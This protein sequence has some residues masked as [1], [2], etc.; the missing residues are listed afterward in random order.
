[1]YRGDF[2]VYFLFV[3]VAVIGYLIGS[4][5]SSIIVGKAYGIDIRSKGSGNAGTT[6]TLRVLGKKAA[7][8]VLVGDFLKGIISFEA[9]YLITGSSH[10]GGMIAGTA[11]ILGHVWPVYFGFKG[12][13]GV[14]TSLAV[15]VMMDWVTALIL[16]AVFAVVV[17]ITRFVSLGSIT[18][19]VML[20]I[21]TILFGRPGTQIVFSL[22]IALLVI[23]MHRGNIKR[24]LEHSESKLGSKKN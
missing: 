13:K 17:A 5:N 18:A 6:N 4:V 8:F 9:G 11:A 23:V 21:L 19:A 16:L 10:V 20:P 7:A 1:L 12:G 2:K 22:V 3:L 15:M 24:L 14:L